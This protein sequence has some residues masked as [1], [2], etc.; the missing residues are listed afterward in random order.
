M[1]ETADAAE[2]AA[3][4]VSRKHTNNGRAVEDHAKSSAAASQRR[5]AD[6]ASEDEKEA[7]I[8]D[9]DASVFANR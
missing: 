6:A 8:A 7:A 4:L 1:R 5:A 3:A 2:L 9:I